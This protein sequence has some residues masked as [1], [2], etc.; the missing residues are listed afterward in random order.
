[1]V[2]MKVTDKNVGA[3]A[4]ILFDHFFTKLSDTRTGVQYEMR[5]FRKLQFNTGCISPISDSSFAGCG[6]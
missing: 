3:L 6:N 4:G 5:T 1:M 2:P